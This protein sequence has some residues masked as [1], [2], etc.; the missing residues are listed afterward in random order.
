MAEAM[1]DR[2]LP[3]LLDRLTDDDPGKRSEAREFKVLSL[4][5]L[6]HNVL[7]DLNWLLNATC[8]DTRNDL[9]MVLD[10]YPPIR[11]SV[12]NFGLPGI[13]GY[14]ATA[15][16]LSDIERALRDAI[17]AFEPRLIPE[18]VQVRSVLSKDEA[19]HHH[20]VLK[21]RIQAQLWAQ[22]AP[23]ELLIQTDLDL[24]SGQHR[25]TEVSR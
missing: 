23:I 1:R 15:A 12:M 2:L 19:K 5:Q 11:S 6:R 8:H 20:N 18:T 3:S 4:A 10:R 17:L 14:S 7:R 24:E 13:A 16:E 9:G 22:P 25:V 21:F